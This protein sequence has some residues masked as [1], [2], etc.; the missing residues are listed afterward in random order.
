MTVGLK[1]NFKQKSFYRATLCVSAVF[2]VARCVSVRLSVTL[3]RCTH[4]AEQT[5]KLLCRPGSS[6]ILVFPRL[7][8]FSGDAKYTGVYTGVTGI[9]TGLLRGWY[10]FAIFH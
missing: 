3:V 4:N 10:I 2:A 5:V 1:V 6:I 8:P 7:E 9:V